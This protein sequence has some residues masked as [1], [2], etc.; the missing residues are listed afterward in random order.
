MDWVV[1]WIAFEHNWIWVPFLIVMFVL[2]SI[3]LA[4]FLI[5]NFIANLAI[6]YFL[7]VRLLAEILPFHIFI[8]GAFAG[9]GYVVV[10]NISKHYILASGDIK[11]MAII[12]AAWG[13]QMALVMFIA[14]I[15]LMYAM[16][17]GYNKITNKTLERMAMGP[18]FFVVCLACYWFRDMMHPVFFI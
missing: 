11:M 8:I 3:D 9:A 12:G 15:L 10:Y 4:T 17:W 1:K 5:P 16:I 2:A 13:W 18:I 14:I 6:A 7:V